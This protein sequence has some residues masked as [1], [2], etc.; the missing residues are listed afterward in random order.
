MKLKKFLKQFAEGYLTI[1]VRE[2]CGDVD[3]QV[4]YEGEGFN[5]PKK[6]LDCKIDSERGVFIYTT[7]SH[8]TILVIFVINKIY[9]K[10]D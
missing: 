2:G 3:F 7:S 6:L 8:D 5:I 9:Y 1:E 10:K 4:L